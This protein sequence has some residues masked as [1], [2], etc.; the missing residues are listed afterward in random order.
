MNQIQLVPNQSKFTFNDRK[1]SLVVAPGEALYDPTTRVVHILKSNDESNPVLLQ[2]LPIK[3]TETYRNR[4]IA[5]AA[6]TLIGAF[7]IDPDIFENDNLEN[8][9]DFFFGRAV[10]FSLDSIADF[11][12]E[13][14]ARTEGYGYFNMS[15]G[16]LIFDF[17]IVLQ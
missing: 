11:I 3:V 5:R 12:S 2:L 10:G 9:S 17:P 13:Q 8:I 16:R 14:T 7:G 15:D 6:T 1:G 4:A